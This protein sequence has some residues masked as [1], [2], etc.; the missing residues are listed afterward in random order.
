M[1]RKSAPNP[2]ILVYVVGAAAVAVAIVSV[3]RATAPEPPSQ[4]CPETQEGM[5]YLLLQEAHDRGF[6]EGLKAR[7]EVPERIE[8]VLVYERY[9]EYPN[10]KAPVTLELREPSHTS[11]PSLDFFPAATRELRRSQETDMGVPGTQRLEGIP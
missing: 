3:L 9:I 5:S 4:A 1:K 6:K 11:L 10:Q 7:G 2:I 8:R